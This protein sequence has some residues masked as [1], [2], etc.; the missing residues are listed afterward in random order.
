MMKPQ[1]PSIIQPHLKV[2]PMETERKAP[3]EP[4]WKKLPKPITVNVIGW[5][6]ALGI[7]SASGVLA[8]AKCGSLHVQLSSFELQ[9]IKGSC[10]PFDRQMK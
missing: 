8:G 4:F 6:T 3:E 10:T 5:V 2:K 9:L 7:L 1:I